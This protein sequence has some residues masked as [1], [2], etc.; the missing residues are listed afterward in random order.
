MAERE[1]LNNGWRKID[2]GNGH[3]IETK[4]LDPKIIAKMPVSGPNFMEPR[5]VE[6]LINQVKRILGRR[7]NSSD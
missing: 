6:F 1:I 2:I 5:L 3:T 7:P 4:P